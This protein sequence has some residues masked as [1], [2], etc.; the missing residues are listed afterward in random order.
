R[1][2]VG[3]LPLC[4]WDEKKWR[5]KTAALSQDVFL[6]HAS[7]AENIRYGNL[8]ASYVES[9]LAPERHGLGAL[10]MPL[11]NDVST[12]QGDLVTKLSGGERQRVALARVLVRAPRVWVFDA[13]TSALDGPAVTDTNRIIREQAVDRVTF[14]IAHRRV[15]VATADRVVLMDHG[16]IVAVGRIEEIEREDDLFCRL[17]KAAA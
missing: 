15:S 2:M 14:V 17:F 7:L 3:G 9:E 6:F 13:P 8:D 4:S 1:I 11:P 16:R 10:S 12:M 5:A